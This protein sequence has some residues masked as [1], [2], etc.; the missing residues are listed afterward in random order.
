MVTSPVPVPES[1]LASL[2]MV[3]EITVKHATSSDGTSIGWR[4]LGSGPAVVVTHGSIGSGEQWLAVAHALADEYTLLIVD[5][6]GRGVTGDAQK[7]DL[8]TE[9]ADLEAVLAVAGPGATLVGHSYGAIVA[10]AAAAAGVD[11]SA[12]VLYEPPLPVKGPTREKEMSSFAAAVAAGEHDR[13]LTIMVSDIVK[14]S[15]ADVARMRQTPLWAE[16]VG[17]TPTVERELRTVNG[18]VGDLDRFTA[19]RQRTLL[20]L[21]SESPQHQVDATRFLAGGLPDA[22][23]VELAGQQHHANVTAPAALADAVRSFLRRA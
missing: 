12:L 15:D 17:R 13:A 19:I 2:R 22:T 8:T 16:M 11:I 4:Q 5:R 1:R 20:L 18:L 23:V 7:Y 9:V 14:M 21:G 6:R 10:A 3:N